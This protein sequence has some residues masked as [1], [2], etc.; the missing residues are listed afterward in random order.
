M[1]LLHSFEQTPF[2]R[3]GVSR[4]CLCGGS[5]LVLEGPCVGPG[6]FIDAWVCM[7][8][9]H[10]VGVIFLVFFSMVHYF[11]GVLY[12]FWVGP[13]VIFLDALQ[14]RNA[15]DSTTVYQSILVRTARTAAGEV[16]A[17]TLRL[18]ERF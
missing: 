18:L 12:A 13:F 10:D 1:E 7:M 2:L 11:A 4:G 16:H 9:F 17:M 8:F 15:T 6:V 14:G 3:N 5:A